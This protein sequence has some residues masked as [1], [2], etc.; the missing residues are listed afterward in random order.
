MVDFVQ[1]VWDA[2]D[3]LPHPGVTGVRQSRDGYIWI[4]TYSGVVR[5][6]GVDFKAPEVEGRVKVALNDH[7]RAFLQAEDGAMWFGTRREGAIRVLGREGQVVSTKEGLPHNEVRAMAQTKDGTIWLGTSGGLVAR[8]PSGKLRTFTTEHGLPSRQIMA[9]HAD[10]DGTLWVGTPEFGVARSKG[11]DS[12]EKVP[13]DFLRKFNI[14]EEAAGMGLTTVAALTRDRDGNLWAGTSVGL[15]RIARGDT[16]DPQHFVP[17]AFNALWPSRDG[18][19]WVS[20]GAGLGRW[21][22]GVWRRYTSEDGI[23]TEGLHVAYEDAEGSIW[24]GTRLGLA[25]LRPRMIRTYTRRDGVAHESIT[26]VFETRDGALWAGTRNG[27]SRFKD[28]KW[29]TVGVAEGMPH[30]SVRAFAEDK[31]GGLWIGTLDGLARYKDG[32]VTVVPSPSKPYSVRG[33]AV[34]PQGT[35]WIATE[36]LDRLEGRRIV[37]VM[38]GEAMCDRSPVNY[39]YAARD[40][41]LWIGRSAALTHVKDGR[42]ECFKDTEVLARNDVRSIYEDADGHTWVL[43]IGG[44]SQLR[45]GK[46]ESLGRA[47]SPLGSAIY[48]MLDDDRGGYWFSTPRGLLRVDKAEVAK[49]GAGAPTDSLRM[50]GTADGMDSSVGTGGGVPTAF[51]TR[52]GRLAFATAT[53][54][55]VVDPGKIVIDAYVPPVYVER[56]LADHK[57]VEVDGTARLA[58]GT[59]DVEL[60]FALLSFVAPERAQYKYKLEGHDQDWVASGARRVAYYSNLKPGRHRFRVLAANHNGIWNEKGATL[61]FELAPRFYETAWFVPLLVLGFASAGAGAYRVRVA[62]LRARAAHLQRTV[63]EALAKVHVLSGML[64]ICASCR[65]VREDTGYWR[66]IEAYV[67]ERS[68]AKFSHGVCPDCWDKM[69]QEDPGLP[70]YQGNR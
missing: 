65:R 45:N 15:V 29:T 24:L 18:I 57:P 30:D 27:A 9:L 60:H 40:G 43:G 49:S 14:I 53:G 56:L 6:D 23:V 44:L 7:V 63:D 35:L 1:D 5:F 41:S 19:L 21:E 22:N 61:E 4:A 62:A 48:G 3:G 36:S 70:E 66:Q 39:L 31:D 16:I 54:V 20:S 42:S 68:A 25:R 55:A 33:L 11:G 17:G 67:Q 50:F 2:Q 34:D 58:P 10:P 47:D 64:P 52:D 8:D 46:I 59:R 13:L 12:F 26:S 28:G 37:T 32:R 69:R 38:K 51:R